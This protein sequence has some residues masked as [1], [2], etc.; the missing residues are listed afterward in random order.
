MD[1]K[2]IVSDVC[3]HTSWVTGI[4]FVFLAINLDGNF[5]WYGM[6]I[7]ILLFLIGMRLGS[8]NGN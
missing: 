8:E 3:F 1:I 2:E 7:S 4:I 5:F 6:P